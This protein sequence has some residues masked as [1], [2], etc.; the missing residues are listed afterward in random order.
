[1]TADRPD[2]PTTGNP[3]VAAA[4]KV[5]QHTGLDGLAGLLQPLADAVTANP[6]LRGLLRARV[7]GH[8]A[9][10]LL[11]DIP[12]GT[13]LSAAVLDLSRDPGLHPASQKLVGAGVL[14][15]VPTA[16][17]GLAEYATLGTQ[18]RRVGALHAAANSVTLVLNTASWFARRSGHHRTGAALSMGALAV[19]N[20]GAFLGGH[21]ALARKVSSRAEEFEVDPATDVVGSG[22]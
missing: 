14:A 6:D 20:V 22:I 4:L 11:T 19:G 15:A 9:H 8:A 10:P 21:L 18:N 16:L 2:R 13:W 5:E 12:L 7:A 3:L 1:M 17:T